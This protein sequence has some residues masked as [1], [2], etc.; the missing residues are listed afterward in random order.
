MVAAVGE[1]AVADDGEAEAEDGLLAFCH[2]FR[3]LLASFAACL[4]ACSACFSWN[5]S[6]V[7]ARKGLTV[8]AN[9]ADAPAAAA[10]PWP[11][12]V[13]RGKRRSFDGDDELAAV[14]LIFCGVCVR[15]QRSDQV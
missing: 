9:V 6:A 10:L 1:E 3:L 13:T 5:K 15:C 7:G 12:E 4:D 2:I 8:S 11:G 14:A